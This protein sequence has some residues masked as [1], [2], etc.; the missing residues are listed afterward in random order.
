VPDIVAPLSRTEVPAAGTE[1][2]AAF[3]GPSLAVAALRSASRLVLSE[4]APGAMQSEIRAMSVEC[5][6]IG[7]INLAQGVC[8]TPVPA[9]V[10]EGAIAAI[11]AGYNIYTRLDGI[12]RLRTAIAKKQLHDYGLRY[13]AE[14]EILVASGAT[15]GLH[16]AAMALLNPGDEVLL[17]EPF[18]GYHVN[19]LKS[20][21]VTPVLVPLAEPDWALDIDALKAAITPRTRA[22]LLNTPANPSGKVFTRAE[23][24]AIADITRDHDLFLFT[25]EIYEYFVYDGA[26]HISP[27]TLPGMRERT[28]VISGFSKTFSITG[29]RLGYVT[30]AAKW[31][32]AMSYFHDLT[33][34]CAPSALQHGAA[35]GLEQLGPSFYQQ[36]AVDHQSKRE[37]MISALRA[38]GFEPSV[39]AGA[40]YVLAKVTGLPGETAALKARHLLAATGVAAVAGSA[41]F[42]QGRGE[43][44]LRFCFAKKD[45]EL[46]EAC[47]RLRKL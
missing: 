11:R 17:F 28:I 3:D 38:A 35:A 44:L 45:H 25:D 34:V 6:R 30:A 19:T 41:F 20:L 27:A 24:E 21:R 13:D 26:E 10:E 1:S 18:Y 46:D 43:D 15:A 32:A 5:D 2:L 36:I 14:T 29:W 4:L 16:A 39:P 40:Y 22:I 37:R 33:Y 9:A 47:V 8:D 42:R 12:A 31:M 7:G 23:I